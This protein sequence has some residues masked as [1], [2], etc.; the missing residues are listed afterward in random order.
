MKSTT[1]KLV[2][3]LLEKE[4]TIAFAESMTCG[5]IT[6]QLNTV[7]GTSQVLKGSVI[8][9]SEEVKKNLLNVPSKL[10]EKHTAESIEVTNALAKNLKKLISADICAAITGLASSGGSE[11]KSK[12]VGTVFYSMLYKNK[13]YKQKKSFR[14]TPL[15]IKKRACE[16]FYKFI[17]KNIKSD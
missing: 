3:L 1:N 5:L 11:R 7:K 2:K 13:I 12:P 9:Y 10:I 6:H 14:G 4:L 8:C 15:E 16:N 17:Y